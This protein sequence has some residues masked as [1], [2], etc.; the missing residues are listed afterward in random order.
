MTKNESAVRVS[1]P[2]TARATNK[3]LKRILP[4]RRVKV[5]FTKEFWDM[6]WIA[7]ALTDAVLLY[8]LIQ[9]AR[10]VL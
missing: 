7:I 5:T 3:L 2:N 6:A 4:H 1:R 9:I 10:G 8:T